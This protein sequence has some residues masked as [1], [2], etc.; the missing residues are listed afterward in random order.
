MAAAVLKWVD[1]VVGA[2]EAPQPTFELRL[3][4]HKMTVAELIRRRVEQEVERY[5]RDPGRVFEGLVQPTDAEKALNGL[6]RRP[7]QRVD[8]K[9]QVKVALEAFES[10]GFFLLF[11]GRQV[12]ALDEELLVTENSLARFVRLMPLVGG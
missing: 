1:E 4:S 2:G 9:E 5:N 12:T 8:A 7:R 11:D 10:N 6:R 3:V